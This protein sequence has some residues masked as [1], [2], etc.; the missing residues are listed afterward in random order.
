[1]A[2]KTGSITA[3]PTKYGAANTGSTGLDAFVAGTG[4][5][6]V[7]GTGKK[8]VFLYG[9]NFNALSG[10]KNVKIT[11]FTFSI[12]A[13]CYSYTGAGSP[14]AKF[15]TD[16][17]TS[18]TSC[19]TYTDVGGG[20]DDMPPSWGT[21][22]RYE[23]ST[24]YLD[25]TKYPDLIEWL[26]SNIDKLINGYTT[27]SFGIRI[28]VSYLY[29]NNVELTLN[30]T[31]EVP[32]PV[33]VTAQVSPS[34]AG[35]VY[36]TTQSVEEGGTASVTATP[37]DGYKFSHWLINGADSGVTSTTLSGTVTENL[38]V[39][40]VFILDCIKNVYRATTQQ[41]VYKGNKKIQ[42]YKGTTK[43]YG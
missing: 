43:I 17:S 1:M 9:M 29:V 11:G 33:T 14:L 31:Y 5:W 23:H 34:G 39:T 35:T 22:E 19:T 26:N 30:Y 16:F 4:D 24:K 15:V 41:D 18:G 28:G 8:Y 42:V 38:T 3:R 36:P 10:L 2:I 32:E 7:S 13:K 27:N 21:S 12:T 37:N 25:T 6:V 20:Y 40:A